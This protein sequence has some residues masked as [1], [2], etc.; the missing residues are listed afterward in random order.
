MAPSPSRSALPTPPG[1]KISL[2]YRAG[3]AARVLTAVVAGYDLGVGLGGAVAIAFRTFGVGPAASGQVGMMASFAFG[4]AVVV[5]IFAARD[6]KRM[7]LGLLLPLAAVLIV[8]TVG[9]GA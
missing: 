1:R 8:W 7:A 4:A 6:L 9:N 2:A 3:V 5:W